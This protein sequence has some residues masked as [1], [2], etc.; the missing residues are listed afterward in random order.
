VT[1]DSDYPEARR[2]LRRLRRNALIAAILL[3]IVGVA[4]PI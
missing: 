2:E 3:P 1:T 4:I